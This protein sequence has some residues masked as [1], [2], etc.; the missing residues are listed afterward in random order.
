MNQLLPLLSTVPLE[1]SFVMDQKLVKRGMPCEHNKL[2]FSMS[3]DVLAR[4]LLDKCESEAFILTNS[5]VLWV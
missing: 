1:T 2:I 3:M 5:S 4:N